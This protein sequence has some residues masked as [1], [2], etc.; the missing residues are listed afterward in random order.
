[1]SNPAANDD[2]GPAIPRYIQIAEGLIAQIETGAFAPGDRLPPERELSA[3]LGVTRITLRQALHVLELRGLLVRRQGAGTFVAASK[4]DRAADRL[5]PFSKGVRSQGF[6]PG[7]R[8]IMIEQRPASHI[9]TVRLAL[10]PGADIY[11]GHRLRT[12]NEEPV[13][14]E[15]FAMPAEPFPDFMRHDIVGRSIYEI[16]ETE[17]GVRVARA[18]QSLEPILATAYEANLLMIA[19]GSPLM[20]E[21]RLTFDTADRP[22]EY[23]KD[24]YRGDRFRFTIETALMDD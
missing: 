6:M 12:V 18:R 8:L 21:R 4:I 16:M 5:F 7:A 9:E 17:Y 1:M 22:V 14:L 11:Y 24:L 13:M 20:I 19:A 15:Q 2:H 23:S 10:A 3:S